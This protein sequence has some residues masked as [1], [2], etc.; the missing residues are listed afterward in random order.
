MLVCAAT[1][2]YVCRSAAL[3]EAGASLA[4][5]RVA[6]PQPQQPPEPESSEEAEEEAAD[7]K[8][9]PPGRGR[10]WSGAGSPWVKPPQHSNNSR[11]LLYVCVCSIEMATLCPRHLMPACAADSLC[12]AL[13][14]S[15]CPVLALRL[16]VCSPPRG[17][18][19][20]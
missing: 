14:C 5:Q 11:C 17:A 20:L 3:Q 10:M 13:L 18:W 8:P 19:C 1:A 15:A 6:E 9:E 16:P 4:A 2:V 12:R 7:S